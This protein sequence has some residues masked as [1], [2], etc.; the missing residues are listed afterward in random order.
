[1]HIK[2]DPADLVHLLYFFHI[3]LDV[4]DSDTAEN[5]LHRNC[6][7]RLNKSFFDQLVFGLSESQLIEAIERNKRHYI[8][9]D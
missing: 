7:E 5:V 9:K 8:I 1:M 3:A 4:L 6:I 2:I